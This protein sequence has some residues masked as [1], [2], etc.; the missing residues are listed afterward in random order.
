MG[1]KAEN[2]RKIKELEEELSDEKIAEL[3]RIDDAEI[4]DKADR[5]RADKRAVTRDTI[6]TLVLVVCVVAASLYLLFIV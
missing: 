2:S 6:I 3:F 4:S 1:T 5:A